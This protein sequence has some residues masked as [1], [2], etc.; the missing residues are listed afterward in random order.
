MDTQITNYDAAFA[1]FQNAASAMAG[2]DQ[3]PILKFTKGDW[4]VGQ[5]NEDVPAGTKLAADVMNA[6]WGWVRWH[7][8]KPVERRMVLVASGQQPPSRDALGHED[9][10]LWRVGSD[11]RAQDPWQ[12]TIEIPVRELTGDRREFLLAGSSKGFEGGCKALFNS[13]GKEMRENM[14]KVPVISLGVSKY[15]HSNPE[16]GIIKT[17]EMTLVEWFDPS[18]EAPAAKTSKAKF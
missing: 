7:D 4:M 18:Q 17:P 6:E 8:S 12:K 15:K 16:Y 11:G 5:D 10:Q 1:A 13:F 9:K 14:G 3:K 2:G